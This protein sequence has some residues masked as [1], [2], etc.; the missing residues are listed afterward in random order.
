MPGLDEFLSRELQAPVEVANPFKELRVTAKHFDSA[1]IA[2]IAPAFTVA[3]GLAI[4]ESVFA[5][6]PTNEKKA[7]KQEKKSKSAFSL[8]FGKKEKT[9]APIGGETTQPPV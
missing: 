3:V 2:S 4:R 6:N 7:P 1:A 9:S 8:S 5:A